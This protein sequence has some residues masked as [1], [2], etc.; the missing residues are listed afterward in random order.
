MLQLRALEWIAW[1]VN[2]RLDLAPPL[3]AHHVRA[4]VEPELGAELLPVL[5]PW[6]PHLHPLIVQSVVRESQAGEWIRTTSTD[7]SPPPIVRR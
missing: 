1:A 3:R 4:I 2:V 6:P 5:A 7:Q